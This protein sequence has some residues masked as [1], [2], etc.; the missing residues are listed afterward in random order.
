MNIEKGLLAYWLMS[1]WAYGALKK[2][3]GL[4][5]YELRRH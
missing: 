5:A 1:L 4:L 3:Y 2:A